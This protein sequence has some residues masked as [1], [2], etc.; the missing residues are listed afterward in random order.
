MYQSDNPLENLK[1]YVS[2]FYRSYKT[3]NSVMNNDYYEDR[4]YYR[5]VIHRHL[6]NL[7]SQEMHF[8]YYQYLISH[9]HLDDRKFLKEIHT[10]NEL[11][12]IFA[13]IEKDSL[14]KNLVPQIGKAKIKI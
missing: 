13:L 7:K 10:Q 6:E 12:E 3:Y 1:H 4:S 14:E 11:D 9:I 5:S 2:N 8:Q